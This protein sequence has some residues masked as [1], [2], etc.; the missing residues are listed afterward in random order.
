LV[1][2][3]VASV[4]LD[5]RDV[6]THTLALHCTM[7]ERQIQRDRSHPCV[8]AWSLTNEPGYLAEAEYASRAGAYFTDLFAHARALD[9]SRPLTAANVGGRHGL[10]DPLYDHVDFLAL[11]RYLGWYEAPAQIERAIAMLAAECDELAARYRKP[12]FLSEF[13][14]DAI[15]G[16]HATS[17]QLFSEEYQADLIAAYWALIERHP[18]LIGGHVWN[19]ADFRTAQHHRRVALN[20]K[21]VFSRVRDPKMAAWR[22]RSL[23][24]SDPSKDAE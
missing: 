1:I 6:S 15:P 9:A 18:A 13:G 10:N 20:H 12:L 8:I 24:Q 14:A 17:A 7:I 5:F 2:S 4:N 21:G 16:L 22:L 23:W 3:E 19:F 11:N